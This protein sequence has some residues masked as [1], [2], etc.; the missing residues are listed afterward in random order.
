VLTDE[1]LSKF[2]NIRVLVAP[3]TPFDTVKKSQLIQASTLGYIKRR[4]LYS[5][6]CL[7]QEYEKQLKSQLKNILSYIF[8]KDDVECLVILAQM[9]LI[10]LKNFEVEYFAPAQELKAINCVAF[11][12]NWKNENTIK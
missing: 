1:I 4:E 9:E 5:D 3:K 11:L 7:I 8:E 2:E 6:E 10:S 12:L